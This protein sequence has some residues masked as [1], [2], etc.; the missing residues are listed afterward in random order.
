MRS[1]AKL[2]LNTLWQN[3]TL[4]QQTEFGVGL[5]P[6]SEEMLYSLESSG[7]WLGTAPVLL[8]ALCQLCMHADRDQR[9]QISPPKESWPTKG[10]NTVPEVF[11]WADL[12]LYIQ[13]AGTGGPSETTPDLR[14]SV[15]I[16]G[17]RPRA[18][19]P[20][21]TWYAVYV[22][23][24]YIPSWNCKGLYI[25]KS[26]TA[27][28]EQAWRGRQWYGIYKLSKKKKKTLKD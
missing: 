11:I 9:N 16:I 4:G 3:W 23:L 8:W 25:Q 12:R 26:L 21:W 7:L 17:A 15:D 14:N 5:A 10:L 13:S 24:I 27:C 6:C 22:F 20:Q 2:Y 1:L 28:A 19:W 18:R